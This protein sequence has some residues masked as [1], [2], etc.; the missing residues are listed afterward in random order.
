MRRIT[1]R[2][3]LLLVVLTA[4]GITTFAFWLDRQPDPLDLLPAAAVS[5]HSDPAGKGTIDIDGLLTPATASIVEQM[6]KTPPGPIAT[7][8]IRSNGGGGNGADRLAKLANA[9][10][11]RVRVDD[12]TICSSACVIFLG[13]VQTR[14]LDIAPGAWL[15]VHGR[16]TGADDPV[17]RQPST[18]MDTWVESL[19][20]AWYR[21]LKACTSK[22]LVRD[23]GLAMTW[24]EVKALERAPGSID[25]DRIAY[26]TKDWLFGG[27][28]MP[29]TAAPVNV[30]RPGR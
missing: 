11:L 20:P 21:F 28:K 9:N 3:G 25:C 13:A 2:I 7:L 12:R 22:P 15:R 1:L 5:Y 24:G 8:R 30:I 18:V 10:N 6:V 17:D 26:R 16:S 19:S 4:A 29:A 14:L 23:A 27:M